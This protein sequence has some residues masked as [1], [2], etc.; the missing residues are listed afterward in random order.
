METQG[1]RTSWTN[2]VADSSAMPFFAQCWKV[3]VGSLDAVDG[4]LGAFET[5]DPG[6][7]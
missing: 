2:S 7:E 4:G 6:E 1:R 3:H 5:S